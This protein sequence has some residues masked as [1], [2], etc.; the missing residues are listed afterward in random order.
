LAFRP[1][2]KLLAAAGGV[3]GKSGEIRC[4]DMVT[5]LLI[6]AWT[7]HSDSLYALALHPQGSP[8]CA[9]GYDHLVSLWETL[10]YEVRQGKVRVWKT[11]KIPPDPRMLKDHT[12]AVYGLA[13]SPDGSRLA[14]VAGDRTLKMW[15]GKTGKRLFTLSE[16]TAELYA[17]A[18]RPDGTQ[19]AA[20]GAD[21]TLRIWNVQATGGT[22][23]RAAFA[24]QGAILRVLY[25]PDGKSIY[26]SGE[27][28]AVKQWDAATLD[29]RK[30]YPKQSD[31]PQA[32]ALSPDGKTLAVGCHD[33]SLRFYSP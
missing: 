10:R 32:L 11:R 30:V 8:L 26:T 9:A 27:D 7:A 4:W 3:P 18:F 21:K 5:G 20:G 16:S 12:D 14:S 31:W 15:D 6:S 24:H 29:E 1:D 28:N 22:L 19:I 25:A 17:V 33:G 23:A 13:F 2:G